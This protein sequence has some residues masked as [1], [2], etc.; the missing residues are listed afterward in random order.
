MRTTLR[1]TLWTVLVFAVLALALYGIMSMRKESINAMAITQIEKQVKGEVRIGDISPDFWRTFPNISVQL[2]DVSIRDSLWDIHHHEFLFAEKIYIRIQFLSL[3]T[4]KPKIG[5]VIVENGSVDLYTDECG[6]CNLTRRENLSFNKGEAEIPDFAFYNTRIKIQ[7]EFLN[8]YHDLEAFYLSTDVNKKDSAQVLTFDIDALVHSVGFNMEKGSYLKEKKIEGEFR[9]V[10][11]AGQ[12]IELNNVNLDIDEQPFVFNGTFFLNTEPKTYELNIETKQVPYP[13]AVSILTQALQEKFDSM[14]V[15]SPLD[16]TANIVGQMTFRAKPDVMV[17]FQIND[18]E[19]QTPLGQMDHATLSGKFINRVDSLLETGDENSKLTFNDVGAEFSGIPITSSRIEITNLMDPY[20]ICDL[21]SVFMLN[22]LNSLTESSTIAFSKGSGNLDITFSGPVA[23]DTLKPILNGTLT[24]T[25][26]EFNYLPRNLLFQN[27]F[28]VIEFQNEDLKIKQ[29]LLTA[30]NTKLTMDGSVTN[31]LAM[32]NIHPEQLTMEWNISTPDLDLN[33]FTTYVAAR[34]QKATPKSGKKGKIIRITENVDKLLSDGTAKL[35]IK[36]EN[37]N[38]K[39]FVAR[40]VAA[41]VLLVDNRIV[42]DD[43]RLS[44]AGGTVFLKGSLVNGQSTS[45]LNLES[46][47]DH[48]NIPDLFYSFDNFGQDAITNKNMKGSLSGNVNITGTITDK[49]AVLE[50]SMQG[51]VAFNIQNGELINFEPAM[52]I[53]ATALKNRDFS[54]LKFGELKNKLKIHGPA[55]TFDR[56]EIR[57]N[58]VTLFVEG[59]YDTKKGTDMSIQVPLS[60]LSKTENDDLKNTGKA[61]VN[62]RL[63]AMTADDGTLKVT[64]DPFNNAE[65]QRKETLKEIKEPDSGDK[66]N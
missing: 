37:L 60:N 42:F 23:S 44:H 17:D 63:R 25:D 47:I 22:N 32:L 64:W 10:Y 3:L 1:I 33:D 5:K 24:L 48:L 26:A 2:S 31:L 43:A 6:Y 9:M 58:V 27:G 49:A 28:G 20:V 62:I 65:K 30:G 54:H 45:Q 57:S 36:A 16:A 39:K 56:M 41:S 21:Q 19:L 51:T 15:L 35:N 14:M 18:S 66:R 53:A 4:G 50:N 59:I 8:T 29:L 46:N 7:N 40:N 13:K 11:A 61:G 38:Y 55:I 12:K 34:T 52:K